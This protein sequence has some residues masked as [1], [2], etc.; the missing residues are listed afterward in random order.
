[1]GR[2]LAGSCMMGMMG[3]TANMNFD[4]KSH[5]KAV[6]HK[7]KVFTFYEAAKRLLGQ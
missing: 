2:Q 3:W 5:M 7:G 4:F 6:L 1:M